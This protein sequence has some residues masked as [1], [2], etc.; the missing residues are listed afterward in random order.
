MQRVGIAFSGG[1]ARGI[2]SAT[3]AD[4]LERKVGDSLMRCADMVH[5]TS[6]GGLIALAASR[7]VPIPMGEMVRLYTDRSAEMFSDT[8]W[9]GRKGLLHHQYANAPLRRFLEEMFQD[10]TLSQA[11]GWASVV[12]FDIAH[13]VPRFFKTWK[14]R[15]RHVRCVDA[16]LATSAAWPTYFACQPR[17][18]PDPRAVL[19]PDHPAYQGQTDNV[20]IDGGFVG[21]NPCGF[22]Y[23]DLAKNFPDDTYTIISIGTGEAIE[24][25][26]YERA[27]TGGLVRHGKRVIDTLFDASSDAFVYILRQVPTVRLIRLQPR[28]V[29]ADAAMDNA[30]PANIQ[31]LRAD[32]LRYLDRVMDRDDDLMEEA[33]LALRARYAEKMTQLAPTP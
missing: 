5:G 20:L 15:D 1:G 27:K 8:T 24:G 16:G 33:A 32:T 2:V 4:V 9:K 19:N 23:A 28:L 6:T 30:S 31:K 29:T 3:I 17:V 13:N 26:R 18:G 21:N 10:H 14:Q 22:C 12:C 25:I 11:S 7:Q